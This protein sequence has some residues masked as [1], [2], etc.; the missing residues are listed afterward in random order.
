MDR[1]YENK[2]LINIIDLT[3][4]KN[5]FNNKA[6]ETVK[7]LIG[8]DETEVFERAANALKSAKCTIYFD[9]MPDKTN[10]YALLE[11]PT[12]QDICAVCVLAGYYKAAK[13]HETL[14]KI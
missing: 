11:A 1:I 8:K 12:V 4:T 10:I 13:F 7:L 6:M 2:R 9:R 5:I 3:N 14:N